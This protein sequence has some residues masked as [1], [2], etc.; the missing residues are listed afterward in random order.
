MKSKN[1]KTGNTDTVYLGGRFAGKAPGALDYTVEAVKEVGMYADDAINAFGFA[2]GGGWTIP[3]VPWS[4][5]L[6]SDYTFA[7]GDSGVADGHHQSFDY[8]YSPQSA[9]SLTQQFAW[10]NL[11]DWRAGVD[12]KPLKKLTAKISFRDYW[13]ANV[14]DSL[15]NWSGVK[16]VTNAKAT[17]AHVGEG[18]DTQL[19]YSFDLRTSLGMGVGNLAPGSYLA[20][21]NKTTAFIYPYLYLLRRL[22]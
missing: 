14:R 4:V 8:L 9:Y 10:K 15:Y 21:S 3:A 19:V 20:Q 7:T 11:K 22:Q 6:N 18:L 16:T 1:G 17:S 13:L 12:F 2:V 5:R